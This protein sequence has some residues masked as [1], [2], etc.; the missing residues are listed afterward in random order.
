MNVKYAFLDMNSYFA[1]VEQRD[2][3]CLRGRPV[4]VVPVLAET[5]S[6]IAA[7]YEAKRFGVRT[8]TRVA[9][10]RRL[11]PGLHLVEARPRRYVEVH[12][13]LIRAVETCLPVH[14]V[15]SIDEMSFRLLGAERDP[16]QAERLALRMKQAICDEPELGAYLP[17][18]IGL[19]PN[20][21][22]AKVAADFRKPDGL[23]VFLREGLPDCLYPLELR[24]F[25]GIGAR[26][27][28]RLHRAGVT[29]V[30]RFCDLSATDLARVWGSK[31]LGQV[32]WQRLRG[33]DLH[34]VPT[35]R[36]TLGHSHVL[37]PE[38]RTET[39]ARA[40]VLR[41]VEKAAARLRSIDYWAGSISVSARF[42]EA[43]SWGGRRRIAPCQDS[44]TLV[45]AAGCLWDRKPTF[46][47]LQ[48][49]V[50]FADLVAGPNVALPLFE[51]DRRRLA[52]ARAVD[53][54]NRRYG[55]HSV[56][57]GGMHG[58]ESQ[59]PTRIAF[60]AI[61]DLDWD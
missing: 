28:R 48:V 25:P 18:S 61:P 24:D 45:R 39:R 53:A 21:W 27:E 1:S 36:R 47:P 3:P 9:D 2:H 15:R 52:L 22:L 20:E 54:I 23:T 10:A 43:P 41:L 33:D 4:A 32:W 49:G 51:E 59:A 50:T 56:Y 60:G 35:T 37:A 57:L 5:T 55:P 38:W 34:E 42:L 12:H 16:E 46:V 29:T 26:M 7:S 19:A 14:A 17:C 11:C 44:L 8:G 40:V 6:C 31:L 13:Q 58:A 30:E